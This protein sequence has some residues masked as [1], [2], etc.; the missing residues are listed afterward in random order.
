MGAVVSESKGEQDR[1]RGP[2]IRQ[3]DEKVRIWPVANQLT[4]RQTTVLAIFDTNCGSFARSEL[5]ELKTKR[6]E[7]QPD[8]GW[9]DSQKE[10]K[11]FMMR[12]DNRCT[13]AQPVKDEPDYSIVSNRRFLRDDLPATAESS[14]C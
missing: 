9:Q 2:G 4:K 14:A 5:A 11:K 7:I 3:P 1:K 12:E 8:S 10:S 13:E 6:T